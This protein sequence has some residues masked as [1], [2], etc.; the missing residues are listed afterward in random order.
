MD[1]TV[2]PHATEHAP[3]P[4]R[5]WEYVR[6]GLVLFVITAMEVGAYEL[7]HRPAA[8]AHEFFKSSLIPVLIVLSAI[9]FWLVAMFYMHLKWDGKLLKGIFSFSLLIA[10]V[11]IV[12]LMVLAAYHWKFAAQYGP[13]SP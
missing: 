12:A 13:V 5:A 3:F 4:E 10:A 11:V 9:K 7:A 1:S 2:T 8:P 6:I